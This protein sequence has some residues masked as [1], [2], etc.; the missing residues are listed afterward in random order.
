LKEAG[1][2]GRF[3]DVIIF[4]FSGDLM[5]GKKILSLFM[6]LS[7]MLSAFRPPEQ[8][9]PDPNAK[10]LFEFLTIINSDGS[11]EFKY[12]LKISQAEIKELRGT[13]GFSE[14]KICQNLTDQLEGNI[15]VFTQEPHGDT[16]WCV[17]SKNFDDLDALQTQLKDDFPRLSIRRLE[18]K[19]GTFYLDLSWSKFPCTTTDS[20]LFSC[21]WAVD[22]PGKAG[23]NN[24]T[25]VEGTTLTWDMS[26]SSAPYHFTAQSAVGSGFLGMDPTVIAV[27]MFLMCGCCLVVILIGGGIAAYLILRKRNPA[28]AAPEPSAAPEPV[29]PAGP[30]P[31]P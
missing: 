6:L 29:L 30:P 25:R 11:A 14:T 10:I 28:T 8:P 27:L 31:Q 18:I 7:L 23:D 17:M 26:V 16:I 20:S 15:G 22:M 4:G 21:E 9:R 19:S 12:I 5:N 13:S 3:A 1:T 24:A 2:P